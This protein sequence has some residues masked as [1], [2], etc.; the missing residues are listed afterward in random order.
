MIEFSSNL[1]IEKGRYPQ[2]SRR[3]VAE[4]PCSAGTRKCPFVVKAKPCMSPMYLMQDEVHS[5]PERWYLFAGI[6]NS[7]IMYEKFQRA[8]VTSHQSCNWRSM[9]SVLFRPHSTCLNNTTLMLAWY[10]L[11][12]KNDLLASPQ[13]YWML[14]QIA[15]AFFGSLTPVE[16]AD[17]RCFY[18]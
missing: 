9:Y 14:Q 7:H 2:S 16:T 15:C 12:D 10:L 18:S 17:Q 1:E 8:L 4:K 13:R 3:Q 11:R 6:K 5:P